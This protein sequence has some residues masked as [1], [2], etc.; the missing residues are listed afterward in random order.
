MLKHT[1]I[2]I[3]LASPLSLSAEILSPSNIIS[4]TGFIY[5]ASDG[6]TFRVNV[7]SMSSYSRLKSTAVASMNAKP[8][9]KEI[10]RLSHYRDKYKSIKIR[11][12][13]VDT[14]ESDHV[15]KSRNTK[16]GADISTIVKK[17]LSKKKVSYS[18]WGY[19]HHGRLICSVNVNGLGDVGEFLIKNGYSKYIVK[20]GKHPLYHDI[21]KS[22]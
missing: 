16:D 5:K 21:Y 9:K 14:P 1:L 17:A 15:D 18:C 6:D 7:D 13:G 10:K 22:L 4:G 8:T 12:A 2:L 19:G 20:Y 11:L 3:A